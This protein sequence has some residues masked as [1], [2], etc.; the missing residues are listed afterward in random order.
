ME[1][2][3]PDSL[4]QPRLNFDVLRLIC[5]HLTKVSDVLSFALTCSTLRKCAFQ[6]RLRMSPV[7]LSSSDS[8][9]RFHRFIFADPTS[10]AP[11]LYG[12]SISPEFYSAEPEDPS[13]A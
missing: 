5:D 7:A 2:S 11:H 4:G 9:E 13:C 3:E 6:R 1:L 12:L 10:R 8:V